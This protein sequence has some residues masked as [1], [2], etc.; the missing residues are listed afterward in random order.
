[1]PIYLKRALRDLS[2]QKG[3]TGFILMAITVCVT[4]LGA[5]I[6]TNA[7]FN[8]ALREN[9][10]SANASDFTMY[11]SSFDRSPSF[12]SKI[13]GL[14]EAEAKQQIRARVKIG[15]EFHNFDLMAFSNLPIYKINKVETELGLHTP[16]TDGLLLEKSTIEHF[17]L[18]AGDKVDIFIP[19]QQ[20]QRITIKGAVEDFSRIPAKFSGLGVGYLPKQVLTGLGKSSF[21]Q[22]QLT[23]DPQ[24]PESKK[25]KVLQ[26]ARKK[27][28]S[29]NIIVFRT[30]SSQ[31]TLLLRHT[32]VN[33]VLLL[34]TMLGIFGFFLA[35]LLIIHLF[36]RLVSEQIY[37]L[38]IQKVLGAAF[39]YL[40]KQLAAALLLI[41]SVVFLLSVSLGALASYWMTNYILQELNMGHARF[42][43]SPY[44]LAGSFLLSFLVPFLAAAYPFQ[45]AIKAPIIQG[46]RFMIRPYHKQK[47]SPLNKYFHLRVLSIRN[48]MAKKMQLLTNILMLSFGGAVIIA[49]TGLN[50]SLSLTLKEMNQFWDYDSEWSISTSLPSENLLQALRDIDGIKDVET[51]TSRNAVISDD[52]AK[53]NVLLHSIPERT[54]FIHP[55]I[56]EGHWLDNASH[57]SIIIS[58]DL[59]QTFQDIK[60]GDTLMVQ[61]G[62]EEKHWKVAGILEKQLAGPAIYMNQADYNQWLQNP[63]IN[64]LL[65]KMEEGHSN[66]KVRETI[67][68]WLLTQNTDILASDQANDIK[69]RP[70]EIIGLL[71]RALLLIGILFLAVGIFNLMTAMSIN[72]LERK[73]EIGIIRS[74]G[75]SSF[76][77][78]Q[79]FMGEGIRIAMISW[80]TAVLLSFPLQTLLSRKMG[81]VLVKSALHS[82][83]PLYGSMLWLAASLLIGIISSYFP[84]R[85]AAAQP[86]S[87]LL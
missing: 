39:S 12:L 3:R 35:F 33:T 18:T 78:Y 25:N 43:L 17:K 87:K 44:V 68:K 64:R 66:T 76:K 51:W 9:T 62:R 1:M 71:I 21:N 31:E 24:L 74:I 72:V 20:P 77:I 47:K 55:K 32:I 27:L 75:G 30:E 7:A 86:V 85:K 82:E 37:E 48:L 36:Y 56:R 79:L 42:T 83:M 60:P 8:Q 11:T 80:V 69:S 34:L 67:E 19:G 16:I 53:R 38:T 6:N 14:K 73:K 29:S 13:N 26:E 84:V 52:S 49:C 23:L 70:E 50:H 22:I 54:S 2:R 5:L 63:A 57:D 65:V 46:L 10:Q 41:C 59:K 15:N 58:S 61:I 45:K 40:W 81:E 28:Q 4:V